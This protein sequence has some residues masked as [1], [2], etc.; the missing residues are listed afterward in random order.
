[1]EDKNSEDEVLRSQS[2]KRAKGLNLDSFMVGSSEPEAPTTSAPPLSSTEMELENDAAIGEVGELFALE[3]H[4]RASVDSTT[5]VA[6]HGEQQIGRALAV[7]M[8]VVWTAIGAMVGTVL[9]PLLG[10]A[11]LLAMAMFGLYLGERW[12]RRDSMH[13]LGLTWV[14]ISMKLLYGLALDAWRWGWLDDVGFGANLSLIHISEPT[15]PY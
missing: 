10:G 8:V 15:R 11:G 7:T 6:V 4:S 14:I 9:P 3:T 1:M 12:I 5:Q 13:L 2:F